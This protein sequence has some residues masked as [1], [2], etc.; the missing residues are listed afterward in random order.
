[1]PNKMPI[2]GLN[3]TNLR[4]KFRSAMVWYLTTR[5]VMTVSF[6]GSVSVVDLQGDFSVSVAGLT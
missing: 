6:Q 5:A 3:S 2:T 1:M 4:E